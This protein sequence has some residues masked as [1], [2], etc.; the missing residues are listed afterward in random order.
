[1]RPQ[2]FLQ[3]F[4]VVFFCS[5]FSAGF[6]FILLTLSLRMQASSSLVFFFF[7]IFIADELSA[8]FS[9]K[10]RYRASFH[11]ISSSTCFS[12]HFSSFH[13]YR[14]YYA[15]IFSFS[16]FHFLSVF[17]I[18]FR[19]HFPLIF[20]ADFSFHRFSLHFS[21][22]F[23]AFRHYFYYRLSPAIFSQ[24]FDFLAFSVYFVLDRPQF[25]SFSPFSVSHWLF[26]DFLLFSPAFQERFSLRASVISAGSLLFCIAPIFHFHFLLSF[27]QQASLSSS[28]FHTPLIHIDDFLRHREWEL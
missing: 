8:E 12:L 13:E 2:S 10:F 27:L 7:A 6:F 14:L 15:A 21:F 26:K 9:Y 28:F 25:S 22:I 16:Y 23:F 5:R 1:M 18:A 24:S 19:R 3:S 4:L 17:I 20:I 11:F